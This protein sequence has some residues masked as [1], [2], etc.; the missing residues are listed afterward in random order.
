MIDCSYIDGEYKNNNFDDIICW[1]GTHIIHA[2]F[3]IIVSIL[4]MAISL[5]VALTYF[6]NNP[7]SKDP[8]A[9]YLLFISSLELLLVLMSLI[10]STK[11]YSYMYSLYLLRYIYI[12]IYKLIFRM[13]I[14]GD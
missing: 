3:S 6:E 12:Y 9:R 8:S 5:V 7:L 10:L 14:N 4:F 13:N 1:E 11:L 2:I